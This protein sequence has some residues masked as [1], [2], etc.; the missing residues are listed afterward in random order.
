[1]LTNVV[2][3]ARWVVFQLICPAGGGLAPK[4]PGG[5]DMT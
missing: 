4:R 1:M 2:T 5:A 3:D